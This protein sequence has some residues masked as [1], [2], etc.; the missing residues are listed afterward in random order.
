M[1]VLI[2]DNVSQLLLD[3]LAR[4]GVAVAYKPGISRE[5]LLRLVPE[6]KVLVVRSRTRVDREVLHRG[7]SG[8]LV[9]VVR[10]GIG[11]DNIDLEEAKRLG[12]RVYNTPEAP[13]ESVA[14]LTIG[15]MIAAARRVVELNLYAR[16]GKWVKGAGV[17]LMGKNLLIAG[18]GRIG[19]RVAELARAFGMRTYA[20]DLP[21][22]LKAKR[23]L[24]EPVEDLC[25]G[26]SNADF[27]TIHLPLTR[28]TRGLFNRHTLGCVKPGAILVNTSRGAVVEPEALLDAIREGRIAAAALDVLQEEPPTSGAE[29]ELLNHP[30]V[31]VTPHIGS[32]TREAQDRIALHAAQIIRKVLGG[33]W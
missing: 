2:T 11:L 9:A 5:E 13:V 6:A 21:E 28:E 3:E 15:L 12:V 32:Q 25:T 17:E 33:E 4:H 10:A 27:I 20:Y 23:G 18:L 7:A 8:R 22:V 26:L 14:E 1:E 24:A 30:R 19:S 16:Q 29:L 31:I